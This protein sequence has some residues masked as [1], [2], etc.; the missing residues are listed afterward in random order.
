M[1]RQAGSAGSPISLTGLSDGR[2]TSSQSIESLYDRYPSSVV[3]MP[4]PQTPP[5]RVYR[6]RM[7]NNHIHEITCSHVATD[8]GF[9][10]FYNFVPAPP[11]RSTCSVVAMIPAASIQL[12][13]STLE[14]AQVIV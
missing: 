7:S 5:N 9:I 11:G 8:E 6:V 14:E 13:T 12:I 1:N 4:E 2:L 3:R 10:K